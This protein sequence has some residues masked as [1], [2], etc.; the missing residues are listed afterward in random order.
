MLRGVEVTWELFNKAF[1][2]RFFPREKKEDKVEELSN[3]H[4]G[5]MSVLN[6]SLK[7]TKL[8]KY[9]P[10][11]VSNPSYE[12]S[13]FLTVVFDD[14][15]EACYSAMLHDSMIISYLMVHAQQVEETR[16]KRK[17][18]NEIGQ[19][20]LIAVLQRV[21]FTFKTSLSSTRGSPIKFHLSYVKLV[22]IRFLNL[23]PKM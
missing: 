5:G 9:A 8:S 20:L 6:Y 15:V 21:E 4:Q 13:C 2:D 17:S 16:V 14:L 10:S 19:C 3:L 11:F 12:M 23:S 1:L 18:R 7:F 22:M